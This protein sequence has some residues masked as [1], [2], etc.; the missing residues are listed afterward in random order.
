MKNVIK[1][2]AFRRRGSDGDP[3]AAR[4]AVTDTDGLWKGRYVKFPE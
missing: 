3:R 4:Q 2:L 1:R